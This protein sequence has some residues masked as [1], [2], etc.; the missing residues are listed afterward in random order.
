MI[1]YLGKGSYGTVFVAE[2][3]ATGKQFAIKKIPKC[4]DNLTNAK[5]LLREI[6]ILR[7]L[8]HHNVIGYRG[9]LAPSVPATFQFESPSS[10]S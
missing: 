4:F 3:I 7:M 2:E 5:R 8:C 9:L 1:R 10:H 6:K